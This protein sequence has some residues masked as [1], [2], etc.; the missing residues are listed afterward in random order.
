MAEGVAK[1]LEEA[2]AQECFGLV[3]AGEARELLRSLAAALGRVHA[4]GFS[5]DHQGFASERARLSLVKLEGDLDA[6][7]GL[8]AALRQDPDFVILEE[9]L[10]ALPW[11]MLV[12]TAL[13]GHGVLVR[14]TD[15]KDEAP[16]LDALRRLEPYLQQT[17]SR[18]VV[19]DA[20]GVARVV[21][22]PGGGTIWKRGEPVPARARVTGHE[23]YVPP[24]PAAREPVPP[25]DEA[26]LERLRAKLAPLRRPVFVPVLGEP[27]GDAA[28]SRLPG[29]PLLA[30]GEE[31]PRCGECAAA[32]PL[33]LQLAR[34]DAPA[35]PA[36]IF[37]PRATHLQFFYC[38]SGDCGVRDAAS[39]ASRNKLI[40]FIESGEPASSVPEFDHGFAPRDIVRFERHEETPADDDV[41]GL[42]DELREAREQLADRARDGDASEEEETLAGPR[43]GEKLLGWPN[44][45][46]GSE[47]ESCP[48]CSE[49]LALVFQVDADEGPLEMLFAA[50]GTGHLSQCPRHPDVLAFRWACG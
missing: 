38:T 36:P 17:F 30:T 22:S 25:L 11:E 6:T 27:G 8:R 20:K 43:T 16:V 29:V 32:M 41:P 37:P 15:A 46:Q 31:W 50:D 21:E 2:L 19:A 5:R 7:K 24:P 49:R 23:P 1:V 47:W 18:I 39:P 4:I 28:R 35:E 12:Q 42:D 26:L 45:T 13:T 33:A 48:R 34:A 40:R 44:W 14:A 10:A 9:C 3:V